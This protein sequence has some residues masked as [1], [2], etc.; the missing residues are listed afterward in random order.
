[1]TGRILVVTGT[2]TGVGKTVVTAGIATL[3]ARAGKKVAVVKPAQTGVYGD[4]IGDIGVVRRLAG[5][6]D[7]HELAR[8]RDPIAP[9][10]AARI[11]G[12]P[13]LSIRECA[14]YVDNLAEDHDVVL[15]EGAGG[16]L[17]EYNAKRETLADLARAT[18]AKTLVVVLPKLGTL[19]HTALT[20]EALKARG[21]PIEGVVIGRW[22]SRP[23]MVCRNNIE[24]L[25]TVAGAPLVGA[26]REKAGHLSRPEFLSTA[27]AGLSPELGG[28]FD[29][30]D[31][32]KH[33]AY[34]GNFD[35]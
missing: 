3:A 7:L 9:A 17:V 8:Y 28:H 34:G 16:L 5:V 4:D 33:F 20:L 19:N 10:A 6:T 26:I 15:V 18:G 13:G 14:N 31:F 24:D 23:D 29:A 22:P 30:A 12:E 25:E 27:D 32:R 2:G 21:L 1:M 11:S 35:H